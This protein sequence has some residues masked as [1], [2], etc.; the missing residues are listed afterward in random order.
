[1]EQQIPTSPPMPQQEN[2]PIQGTSMGKAVEPMTKP[3]DQIVPGIS[4]TSDPENPMP[5]ERPPEYTDYHSATEYVINELFQQQTF[6]FVMGM[7]RDGVPIETLTELIAKMGVFKGKYNVDIMLLVL[8][9][10][11]LFLVGMAERI[12]IDYVF[13]E[14]EELSEGMSQLIMNKIN[15]SSIKTEMDMNKDIAS[16]VDSEKTRKTG[17]AVKE[18]ADNKLRSLLGGN[19]IEK[20]DDVAASNAGGV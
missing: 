16:K 5:W 3:S 1:M 13:E 7:V 14:E 2:A 4:L 8:E 18:N 20:M 9:P 11:M 19:V 6:S 15:S 17:D 10:I 12:G